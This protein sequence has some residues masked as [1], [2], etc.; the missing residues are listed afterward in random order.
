MRELGA[1]KD[2]EES[3]AN[4]RR[5]PED[6]S[7]GRSPKGS[8]ENWDISWRKERHHGTGGIVAWSPSLRFVVH[9]LYV[10]SR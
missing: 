7:P 2:K 1:A 6:S 5:T 4:E 9:P 3:G 8:K 10:E